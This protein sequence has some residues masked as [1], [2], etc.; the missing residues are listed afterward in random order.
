[1]LGAGGAWAAEPT[2]QELQVERQVVVLQSDLQRVQQEIG[3]VL[4]M[5]RQ[6]I[7]NWKQ[8]S[9]VLWASPAEPA[10]LTSHPTGP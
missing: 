9:R 3:V 1:M 10:P 6:E 5:Q 8:Y 4:A 2:Q 7:E